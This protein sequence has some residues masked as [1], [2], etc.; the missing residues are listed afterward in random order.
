MITHITLLQKMIYHDL[1]LTSPRRPEIIIASLTEVVI[2][3]LIEVLKKI[4]QNGLTE[5][6]QI[7]SPSRLIQINQYR[8]IETVV[9]KQTS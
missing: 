7:K 4:L 5:G 1:F 8:L 2:F 9:L 6:A 3:L